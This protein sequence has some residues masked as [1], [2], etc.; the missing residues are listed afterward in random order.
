MYGKTSRVRP[1]ASGD[2]KYDPARLDRRGALMAAVRGKYSSTFAMEGS[3]FVATNP[4]PG[5]GI[6]GITATG[7]LA[8][9][10]TL[11]F[12]RNDATADA[13]T[14]IV[15]DKLKLI[16]TAPGNGTLSRFASKVDTGATRIGTGGSAITEVNVNPDSAITSAATIQ[17]GAVA[18]AAATSAAR[19]IDHGQL[20]GTALIAQ[21]EYIIDFG[22]SVGM[23]R[24]SLAAGADTTIHRDVISH[25]PVVLGPADQYFFHHF[26]TSGSSADTFEFVLTYWEV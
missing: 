11:L 3:Y 25:V 18:T 22:G 13:D 4:T 20:R 14:Y 7:T 24:H 10:E 5:T 15:L 9:T 6:A 17:F 23:V 12:M 16:V 2:G 21:D 26:N 1:S 8:D 19:L